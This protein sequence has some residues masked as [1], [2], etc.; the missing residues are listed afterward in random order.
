MPENLPCVWLMLLIYKALMLALAWWYIIPLTAE[1]EP[2][3]D[4]G[5]PTAVKLTPTGGA[6]PLKLVNSDL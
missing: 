2:E 1:L 4:R 3:T 5:S 6:S